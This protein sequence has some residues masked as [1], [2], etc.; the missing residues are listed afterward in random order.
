MYG[1]KYNISTPATHL[2]L[3]RDIAVH[4][5]ED[6]SRRGGLGE[7]SCPVRQA[8]GHSGA[9]L[10]DKKHTAFRRCLEM[11]EKRGNAMLR[12]QNSLEWISDLSGLVVQKGDQTRVACDGI[13]EI[14]Q[15][16]LRSGGTLGQRIEGQ[17]IA[18]G[19]RAI[20]PLMHSSQ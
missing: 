6:H 13:F 9:V 4:G 11:F 2:H 5:L 1:T 8:A 19:W 18:A 16:S 7:R 15:C 12:K 20:F 17:W 10:S 14:C 3:C